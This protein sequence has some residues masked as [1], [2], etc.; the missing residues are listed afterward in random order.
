MY[1]MHNTGFSKRASSS[2]PRLAKHYRVFHTNTHYGVQ[3]LH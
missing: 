1:I 2:K 3:I